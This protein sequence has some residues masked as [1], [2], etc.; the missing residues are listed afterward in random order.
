MG[1]LL[2]PGQILTLDS[3]LALNFNLA[4]YF[5]WSTDGAESVFAATHNSAPIA[6]VL[7]GFELLLPFQVVEKMWL[8]LLL[9]LCAVG[10]S[11]LPYLEESGRFYAGFFYLVNPFTYIRFVSGQWGMLGAYALIPFAV[12][13][14]FRLLEEPSRKQIAIFVL[15]LTLISHLQIHGLALALLVVGSLYVANCAI[16]P[17]SFRRSLPAVLWSGGLFLLVNSFW[18][19]RFMMSGGGVTKNMPVGELGY[20][21]AFPAIDV[22]SLRGAWFSGAFVDISNLV[23]V[24]WVL[25]LPLMVLAVYGSISMWENQ[26]LRW[27]VLGIALAGVIGMVM[28]AAPGIKFVNGLFT[29]LWEEIPLYRGFRDTHKFVALLALAYAY[30]GAFGL[31]TLVEKVKLDATSP[32]WAPLAASGVF[33]VLTAIYAMPIF[34]VWGRVKPTNYPDDWQTV[35]TMIDDDPEDF[36]VL[37]LP[38]HMYMGFDWLPN[39]W[40][41]LANP[42]PSFFSKPVISGDNIEVPPNHSDSSDPRSKYVEELLGR[43]ESISNMGQLV[44]YLDAKYIVLFKTADYEAYGFLQRQNDLQSIFE[45]DSISLFRN[46]TIYSTTQITE[47]PSFSALPA[48]LRR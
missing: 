38:W 44:S 16:R 28:A 17:E 33:I 24:W 45:G 48:D 41:N 1:P 46:L 12:T 5:S 26:R 43:R 40:N 13:S 8:V 22:I 18:I 29:L 20:F 39:R 11:R 27:L 14:F 2:G 47:I 15:L 4:E 30:L 9:F 21:S 34:G 42:A 37:V 31:Q 36:T 19:V 6:A 35:R 32:R 3:P 23:P 25:F 10:A 7:R